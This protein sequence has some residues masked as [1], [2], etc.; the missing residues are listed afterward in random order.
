MNYYL[1]KFEDDHESGLRLLNENE[2]NKL[3]K[4]LNYD[5]LYLDEKLN[6]YNIL[7]ISEEYYN[8]LLTFLGKEFGTFI[9]F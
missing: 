4:E 6:C 7:E 2:L 3:L 1:V 8:K 5:D 9:T